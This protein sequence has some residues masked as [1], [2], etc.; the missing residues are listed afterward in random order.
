MTAT[1]DRHALGFGT[2]LDAA[3][4]SISHHAKVRYAQRRGTTDLVDAERRLRELLGRCGGRPPVR[5][6]VRG[7]TRR[8][9]AGGFVFV[10]AADH[11]ALVTFF[12]DHPKAARR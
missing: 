9:R 12:A 11:S 2:V 5:S 3:H 6:D 10:V 7:A 1:L 4:I 8:Y